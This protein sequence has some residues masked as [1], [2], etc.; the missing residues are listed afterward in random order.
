M[1]YDKKLRKTRVLPELC[2]G[3]EVCSRMCPKSAFT[4]NGEP[5]VYEKRHKIRGK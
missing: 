1:A 4:K 5:L 3:C 2:V